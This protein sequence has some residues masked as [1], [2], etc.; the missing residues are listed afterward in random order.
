[1]RTI[2]FAHGQQENP[3][4]RRH[5]L[6]LSGYVVQLFPTS[7]A[8][9]EALAQEPLPSLVLVDALLEEKHGFDTAREIH[10]AHPERDFP[11]VL[12]STIYRSQPFRDEALQRGAQDYL[13][14]PMAPD[15]FL[16]R[17]NQAIGY[18]VPPDTEKA[19]A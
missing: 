4:T 5:L 12:C 11:V 17:V 3:E 13:V 15:E 10:K 2:Y 9:M 18:F 6:E 8:L 19:A 1:M 7:S 14:F 16:R